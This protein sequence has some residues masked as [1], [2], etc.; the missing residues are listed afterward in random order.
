MRW[1][2]ILSLLL[3]LAVG[4][5]IA[6]Y[7]ALVAWNGTTST[8]VS[9]SPTS[10]MRHTARSVLPLAELNGPRRWLTTVY[11][12]LASME[13]RLSTTALDAQDPVALV[14]RDVLAVHAVIGDVEAAEGL[15]VLRIQGL[16]TAP[17]QRPPPTGIYVTT[18]GGDW[19]VLL[20]GPA[21]RRALYSHS[22][23]VVKFVDG[24]D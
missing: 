24:D 21:D 13:E 16:P 6:S 10:L 22:G 17:V 12:P 5:Y 8:S 3:L 14:V 18:Q 9:G 2:I 4:L 15:S 1:L 7:H 19:L 23:N 11:Q 20:T